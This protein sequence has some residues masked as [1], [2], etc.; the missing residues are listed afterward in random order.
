ML[1]K[2]FKWLDELNEIETSV[3]WLAL[4]LDRAVLIFLLLTTLALPHSIAATQ[5]AWLT[6]MLLAIIRYFIKPRPQIF[7]TR[8]DFALWGLFA[9]SVVSS[10]FSYAPDISLDKLKNA[11]TFLIAYFFGYNIRTRKLAKL[12]IVLLISSCMVNIFWTYIERGIGRGVELRGLKPESPLAQV[13]LKDGD[14]VLEVNGKKVS[15]PE[16]ILTE[17]EKSAV[18]PVKVKAYRP[19]YNVPVEV[20]RDKLLSGENALQKLGAESW[21]INRNWRSAGF[22]GHYTTYSEVLQLMLSLIF[23]ILITLEIKRS[24][25]GGLLILAL[26]SMGGAL[27]LTATRASQ[28]GFL[29]SAAAILI[30]GA[31]R[32]LLIGF[33]ALV[34]PLALVGL[35]VLQQSRQVGFFD[36]QDNSITWRGQVYTEGFNLLISN[37][38]H[39]IVGVGM[40]SIKRYWQQWNLFDKG[41]LPIGHFHSTPLQLAVERGLPALF[42]WLLFVFEYGKALWQQVRRTDSSYWLEKGIYLGA[43]GGLIGFFASSLVHYNLGDQEVAMVFFMIAGTNWRL[44]K[45][46]KQSNLL[47]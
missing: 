23:G 18:N 38:R 31:N 7:G 8:F 41:N 9:W 44:M 14:T 3:S 6:G 5:I 29:L 1:Q 28:L 17:F 22:Y 37:P 16:Q 39:L 40:D 43:L 10:I 35:F 2:F 25:L 19:D 24:R 21:R 20:D 45:K 27:L 13:T 30:C 47:D 32:R 4:W 11:A 36:R 26:L 12:L 33:A 46:L 42:L 34:I 15:T